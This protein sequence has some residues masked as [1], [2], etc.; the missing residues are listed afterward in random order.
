MKNTI[1]KRIIALVIAAAAALTAPIVAPS[2]YAATD[3]ELD[4]AITTAA[5]YMLKT[6]KDPTVGS[7]GGEWAVIGL[8]RSGYDVPDSYYQG[9]YNAVEKY[10]KEKK[11]VLHDKKYTEYSRVILGLT[12]AGYDPRDVAGYDLT[13]ALGDFE[14]TIW[15]GINGPIWALI[16]LDSMGYAIPENKDAKTQ[17]TRE[18][19]VQEILRRQ[20][21]DGGWNLTAGSRGRENSAERGDPDLTG[22]A[23]QALAN[24]Q[25]NPDVKAATDKALTFLSNLQDKEGGYKGWGTVNSE[26][27][28]QVLTALGAL[29]IPAGD[30]RFT[31]NGKTTV[32]NILLF[33]NADGSFRHTEDG[34]GDS[35]MS[36]EQAFYGLVS[37]QRQRD[38]KKSLYD[39]TDAVLRTEFK[40]IPT[41]PGLSGA[42]KDITARPVTTPGRSF[43]DIKNHASRTAIE[44]LASRGIINGDENGDFRPL[45]EMSRAEFSAIVTK[46]LGLPERVSHPFKD[47]PA[48][49]RT[50]P[51]ASAYYYELVNGTSE[52][53]FSPEKKISRVEAAVMISRAAKL[54]GMEVS[55]TEAEI[56][57]TLAEFF[58]YRTVPTWTDAREGLAF[59]YS[60]G[61]LDSSA[62]NINPGENVTRG[63]IA[64][65]I[66]RLLDR[67]ALLQES[68]A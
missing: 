18:L 50:K 56:Q 63:E 20:I 14:A 5:A 11:G 32:D 55:R 62:L 39:M 45:D 25:D 35:Q 58:D 13:V 67:A 51:V 49:W 38:G 65:M 48:D 24:Y 22:M 60:T 66:Y 8:A 30:K 16:A 37:A 42:H 19:Y 7:T 47:V 57:S 3:S 2:A 40:P 6:V 53:E 17:A 52:T 44:A 27:V 34:D 54:C 4:R 31:K 12:A 61:I 15:Q 46:G 36:S 10:V 41:K 28:V 26:S 29:D 59:C 68:A 21:S 23:L 43:P 33:M 64:E 1:A 9:Y